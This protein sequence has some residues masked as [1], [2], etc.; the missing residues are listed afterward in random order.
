MAPVVDASRGSAAGETRPG[1]EEGRDGRDRREEGETVLPC[2]PPRL[3]GR[4]AGPTP[5]PR[6]LT[7]HEVHTLPL[8]QER[9]WTHVPSTA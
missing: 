7:V 6:G 3:V 5:G 1:R 9:W 2:P 4:D 8:R